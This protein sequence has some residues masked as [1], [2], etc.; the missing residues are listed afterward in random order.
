[1]SSR[2]ISRSVIV[3]LSVA[4]GPT[5]TLL[6]NTTPNGATMNV[7]KVDAGTL[8]GTISE[9]VASWKGIP[10][11]AA[12]V[13][14]NRWRP[15]QPV[16][17]WNDVRPAGAYAS[18][19]AQEPFPGDAS[20]LGATPAEDCLY[21]NVW[22]PTAATNGGKLPVLVYIY[23]GGFTNGG[24]SAPILQGSE[25][26]KKGLVVVTFNYRL[27]RF[28]T[29]AHPQLTAEGQSGAAGNYGYM[30]QIEA[31]RWVRRNMAA[32]GGDPARVTIM[33]ES[34]GGYSVLTLMTSP[35]AKNLF[36]GAIVMS[37]GPG[38]QLNY[39]TFSTVEHI[40]AQFGE[41]KGI[42]PADPNAV[43]KLRALP[44]D[45]VVDNLNLMDVFSVGSRTFAAPFTDGRIAVDGLAA[46]EAGAF[47]HIPVMIGATDADIGGK[48]GAMISGAKDL[49]RMFAKR[50]IPVYAYRF[51]YVPSSVNGKGAKHASDVPFFLG[52]VRTKLKDKASVLDEKMGTTIS[53]YVAN[54]AKSGHP[55]GSGLPEWSRYDPAA[56]EI[57]E[58]TPDGSATVHKDPMAS[59]INPDIRNLPLNAF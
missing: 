30:D 34:A 10:F 23:G 27:G 58:F 25:L 16:A 22:K 56:D 55:D 6:A 45:Q 52:T 26:A 49:A 11:A 8:G 31:L 53:T 48:G 35:A 19:C 54:F 39:N 28:G 14:A 3:A 36:A 4:F 59:E 9:G 42:N 20:P 40:G 43:S 17:P 13:G 1:M 44:A 21:L 12:P 50:N 24:A 33:G 7:V 57:M 32:F 46:I 51:S 5:S 2:L 15:P 38:T 47:A 29:F 41:S 37:G 18:D